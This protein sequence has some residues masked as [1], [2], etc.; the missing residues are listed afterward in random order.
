MKIS[1][2]LKKMNSEVKYA[3][4]RGWPPTVFLMVCN[5]ALYIHSHR[6]D[7]LGRQWFPTRTDLTFTDWSVSKKLEIA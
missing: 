3:R 7:P 1:D 5:E 6:N 2:A 4:R